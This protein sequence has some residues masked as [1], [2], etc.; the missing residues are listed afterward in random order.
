MGS[1]HSFHFRAHLCGPTAS[2][3]QPG[4]PR[5]GSPCAPI[6][7]SLLSPAADGGGTIA[8]W[9]D[10]DYLFSSD[11]AHP[12]TRRWEKQPLIESI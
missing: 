9:L 1:Y 6:L 5:G 12:D 4:P 10:A 3:P 11:A 2:C 8:H 7:M